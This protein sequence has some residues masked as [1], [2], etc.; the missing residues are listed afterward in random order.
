MT[1]WKTH[2]CVYCHSVHQELNILENKSGDWFC[3]LRCKLKSEGKLNASTTSRI[4]G[5]GLLSP[6]R[7]SGD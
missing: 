7:S 5:G 2:R 6:R 4:G 3:S 1:K